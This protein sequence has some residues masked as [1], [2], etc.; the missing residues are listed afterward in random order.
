MN[1]KRINQLVDYGLKHQLI[2]NED[3]EYVVHRINE[4]IDFEAFTRDVFE[5]ESIDVILNELSSHREDIKCS[6]LDCLLP[7]PSD[8]YRIYRAFYKKSPRQAT[9]FF[10]Q[11]CLDSYNINPRWKELI[12]E[13]E[14]EIDG[15]KY[16]ELTRDTIISDLKPKSNQRVMNITFNNEKKAWILSYVYQPWVC[17]Q[18]K[19][20]RKEQRVVNQNQERYNEM[21]NFIN[22][23]PHYYIGPNVKEHHLEDSVYD[24]GKEKWPIEDSKIKQYF[25]SKGVKTQIL[26][27]PINVVRLVGNNE[28]KLLDRL[29]YLDKVCQSYQPGLNIK[30]YPMMRLDGSHFHVYV[31]FINEKDLK[32]V[33]VLKLAGFHCVQFMNELNQNH[34][35]LTEMKAINVFNGERKEFISFIQKAI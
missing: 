10:Y 18:A 35:Y 9:T 15:F 21:L 4:F 24:V 31:F 6:L 26:D 33:N 19:V 32:H 3:I 16:K 29:F 8:L 20:Y 23:Y 28:N 27:W 2:Q 5:E 34:D 17:E 14:Q 25:K 22:K 13:E 12:Q 11:F 7:R 1:N 30:L